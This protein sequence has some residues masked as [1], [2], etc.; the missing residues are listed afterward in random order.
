VAFYLDTSAAVK[1][2]QREAGSDELQA[3]LAGEERMLVS[4]LLL[5]T[6]LLRATRRVRPDLLGRARALLDHITLLDV[7]MDVC[8]R[9][10]LLDPD[11][12][13]SLDAI[14][15]ASALTLI[16]ELEGVVAYDVRLRA[17]AVAVG[18]TVIAPGDAASP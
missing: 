5:R 18:L 14:H 3:W 15:L 2:V 8:E 9:A 13:R 6:E 7:S 16:D 12:M 10:G 1:L 11:G 17:A 4:S